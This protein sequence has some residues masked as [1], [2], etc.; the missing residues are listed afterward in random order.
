M[1]VGICKIRLSFRQARSLKDKRQ[2]LRK[3]KDKMKSR[4]NISVA[5]VDEHDYHQTA[6][7]GLAVAAADA[8]HADSQMA[9][10]INMV[11]MEAEIA[12]VSTEIITV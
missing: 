4:F 3:I 6:Q 11:S 10:A 5:E 7:L 12:D 9:A 8:P 1:V 2:A